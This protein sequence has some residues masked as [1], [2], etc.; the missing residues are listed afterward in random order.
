MKRT[1]PP[2]GK[3]L[4]RL[5][6]PPAWAICLL[7]PAVFAT[8][9]YIFAKGREESMWASVVY[10][11]SAYSLTVIVAAIPRAV[12]YFKTGLLNNEL[13]KKIT[14]SSLWKSYFSS[15]SVRGKFS[16]YQG[17]T[18]NFIYA[19]FRTITGI[20]YSSVWFISMAVYYLLLGLIRA[21]LVI[22]FN[23]TGTEDKAGQSKCSKNAAWL[24]LLL[25]VPMGSMILQ[26]VL[27]NS[28]YTYPGYVIYI[29]ALYTFC[30]TG[31]SIGNMVKYR[32]LGNPIL[33]AAKVLNFVA[34]LMSV[35]GLQTAM[36]AQFSND[37]HSF[38]MM[39][40]GITGAFVY[41]TVIIS[42]VLMIIKSAKGRVGD[43]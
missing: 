41:I 19:L 26:M 15:L 3:A 7:S 1:K 17:M 5:L 32:R 22:A 12:R 37:S 20:A 23:R 34:A 24:L 13:I 2:V 36:I 27:T 10:A 21:Y 38:R 28:G 9:I 42:A 40:N 29:S 18:L 4:K 14:Q 6:Y 16:I 11:M 8:L 25:N 35:L 33:S 43:K 31:I 39:M 30:S